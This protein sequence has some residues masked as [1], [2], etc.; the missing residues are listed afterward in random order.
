MNK[1]YLDYIRGVSV[2]AETTK[3]F[4]GC[5]VASTFE[6]KGYGFKIVVPSEALPKGKRCRVTIKAITT[7]HFKYPKNTELVSAVYWIYSSYKFCQ[8]VD[9]YINHCAILRSQEDSNNL[10][11]ILAHGGNQEALPY[12]FSIEGGLFSHHNR[13]GFISLKSFSF[14]AIIR[15][16]CN[17]IFY[18]RT[19]Y[20]LKVFG[21]S[22]AVQKNIWHFD[23]V[24]TKDLGPYKEVSDKKYYPYILLTY[25]LSK[26]N[27]IMDGHLIYLSFLLNLKKSLLTYMFLT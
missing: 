25:R 9:V 3:E 8:P 6:W 27:I 10:K 15:D 16:I 1:L 24:F 18:G 22:A 4:V 26:R 20:V 12:N 7:G 11:F 13:E 5:D 23:F 19:Y 14:I 2:S 17:Y 21:Q